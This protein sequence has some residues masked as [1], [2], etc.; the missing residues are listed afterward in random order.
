MSNNLVKIT[1][2][3]FDMFERVELLHRLMH[4]LDLV[5]TELMAE[6]DNYLPLAQLNQLLIDLVK[7]I[8]DK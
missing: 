8:R 3:S 2:D 5:Q 1:S 4:M 7:E 6:N